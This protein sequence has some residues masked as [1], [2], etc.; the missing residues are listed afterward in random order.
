MRYCYRWLSVLV[1]APIGYIVAEPLASHW[2]EMRPKHAWNDVPANWEN[3]GL[4]PAG[5]TIDLHIALKAHRENALIEAL[6]EVSDP[7]HP[8]YGSHLSKEQ[9]A[10]LVAPYPE[11]LKLVNSWL[12]HYGVSSPISM[13]H[14]GG[15]LTVT[16]V[17]VS[18]ADVLLGA[19]YRIYR[20]TGTNGTILRTISYALPSVLHAHVQT[21]AANSSGDLLTMLSNRDGSDGDVG[22]IEVTP[23]YLRWLYKTATYE[24]VGMSRNTL[25]V[26][27]YGDQSPSPEDLRA[28][29]L[30][31]RHDVE[32]DESFALTIIQINGGRYNP[33]KPGIEGSISTQYPETIAY[34]IPLTYY[35]VGGVIEWLP[36]SN[37][38]SPDDTYLAWLGYVIHQ[39][40]VPLTISIPSGDDELGF[41]PEYT[42][43]LCI[44]FAQ[45]GARGVSVIFASGDHGVGKGQCKDASGRVMFR[46]I[47]PASCPFVTSV[48][49]TMDDD[50]EVAAPLSGG[51]FSYHFSRPWYQDEVV[52]TF[53]QN[54]GSEYAGLYNPGGR[55]ISDISA[56][57]VNFLMLRNLRD[58][59]TNGTSCSAPTVAGIIAL[60]NDFRLA[61]GMDPLGFLNP[62]LYGGGLSGLTDITSGTNPGCNT[63]GFS[64]IKGWDP[65]TG[66]GSPNFLNLLHT[67]IPVRRTNPAAD[68]T[69]NG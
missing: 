51:G 4:P 44:L 43:A 47:F 12:K 7:S 49:G 39:Q 16:G 61:N 34:P 8:K 40:N 65:V 52:L 41:P 32:E 62:W 6:Y 37:L 13:T 45:L 24:P 67:V 14:G 33:Y 53:L 23:E 30:D 68:A 20:Q 59:H 19:S 15:W 57:A 60:L 11:T 58:D 9:V 48:G 50:P 2:N 55:G 63:K 28:F 54:Q 35:S 56:Q 31:H 38:P 25:G 29:M 17:P 36:G 1:A 69:Q 26:V 21:V 42:K 18:Q 5:T 10:E 22:D 46:P 66:L 3:L 64:A 27:D